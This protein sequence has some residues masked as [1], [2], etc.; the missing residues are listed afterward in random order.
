[1]NTPENVKDLQRFLGMVR[2]L[3]KFVPRL[4]EL[5]LPLLQHLLYADVP[6]TWDGVRQRA[7]DNLKAVITSTLTLKFYDVS[8]LI[9]LTC[10][11]GRS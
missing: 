10:D 9:T 1:M 5:S 11:Q 8:K 3:S 6:W 2:Y 7:F 4:S